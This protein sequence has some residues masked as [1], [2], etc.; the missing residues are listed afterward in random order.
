MPDE[1][2]ARYKTQLRKL[3]FVKAVSVVDATGAV[4]RRGLLGQTLRLELSDETSEELHVDL[5]TSNLSKG[6][7]GLL[8][9]RHRH[10]G[11]GSDILVLAPYIGAPLGTALA[12]AGVKFMDAE[13]NCNIRIG[14][15]F[16]ARVQA[17]SRTRT[18]SQ[19]Q[20]RGAGYRVLYALL[21]Q[22]SLVGESSRAVGAAAGTSK[23][24][25]T[26][27]FA[28]LAAEGHVSGRGSRRHWTH[29]T[30]SPALLERWVD[31][32]RSNLRAKL[33]V[34][35]FQLPA[36]DPNECEAQLE[37]VF[38]RVQYGGTAAAYRLT[39]HYRGPLTLVHLPE[40]DDEE[41][42]R[43]RLR[44]MP[45][46][47][48]NFIWMRELSLPSDSEG[49]WPKDS[50]NPLL[51]YAELRCDSDPRAHET[52]ELVRDKWLPWSTAS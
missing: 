22:P 9:E 27:L 8:I 21:S 33:T 31:G 49:E 35:R 10:A 34:G 11:E 52:A 28:R 2:T 7:A 51:V 23:Q 30:P 44:A 43:R 29:R 15:R 36:Q 3:P 16:V 4:F 45:S 39:S 48:G 14:E 26:D 46:S 18:P 38:S 17:H 40:V 25:V 41:K 32:Y 12:D 13:G 19:A 47:T 50:A 24:P 1:Q 37:S 42:M 6:A 5:H 20:M